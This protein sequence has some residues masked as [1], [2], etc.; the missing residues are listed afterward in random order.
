MTLG[1]A[2]PLRFFED[3]PLY[4]R[5]AGSKAFPSD[6][7]CGKSPEGATCFGRGTCTFGPGTC[8][9]EAGFTGDAC[10][11][12]VVDDEGGMSEGTKNAIIGVFV[13]IGLLLLA[14]VLYFLH[15]R[16]FSHSATA[17]IFISYKH[18][19]KEVA[20]RVR[21][22][23]QRQGNKVWMDTQITPGEDWKGEIA[24][25]IKG[26]VCVVFLASKE[27]L[28]SRY[29]RE[30]IL[31]ASSI[32]KPVSTLLQDCLKSMKGGVKMVLMRKQFV[33]IQGENFAVGMEK[34]CSFITAVRRGEAN[35]IDMGRGRKH[36]LSSASTSVV[37]SKKNIVFVQQGATVEE[38][39]EDTE[40]SDIVIVPATADTDVA[41]AIGEQF[42]AVGYKA[43]VTAREGHSEGDD[44]VEV[45]NDI[46]V[47][48][49]AMIKKTQMILFLETNASMKS[50]EC[51]DEIF[52]AYEQATPILRLQI[53]QDRETV[54]LPGSMAMM[55]T[56]S[57]MHRITPEGL[58]GEA[59]AETMKKALKK[60]FAIEKAKEDKA[61]GLSALQK[62]QRVGAGR[63]IS[64]AIAPLMGAGTHP[65]PDFPA[66]A[67][68]PRTPPPPR[69]PP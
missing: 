49:A 39:E 36:F 19:D 22:E 17:H 67:G 6:G 57:E 35:K 13:P 37:K 40:P 65:K 68:L 69:S 56:V 21:K 2:E 52:Y 42:A 15:R 11:S 1:V 50:S 18:S 26:S 47:R 10:Q 51:N 45:D 66:S 27:A 29:C 28:E 7:S 46:Y 44:N 63:R 33:D 32:N 53:A 12:V 43:C 25:A 16:H 14:A 31:F 54:L 64:S 5:Q 23:L 55:L 20:H 9:C 8:S 34:C 41:K 48:N 24:N 59:M 58:K 3:T 38:V 4:Y 60:L 61:D 62:F 30:E